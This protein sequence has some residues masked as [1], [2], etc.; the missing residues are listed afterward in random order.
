MKSFCN[1]FLVL[2]T[3]GIMFSGCTLD[4][5]SQQSFTPY[6]KEISEF[7]QKVHGKPSESI[8]LQILEDQ[9]ISDEE[10]Q[11]LAQ[12]QIKCM[13]DAGIVGYTIDLNT[14]VTEFPPSN[15][16]TQDQRDFEVQDSCYE[17]TYFQWIQFLY[18]TMR[19]NP[20]NL[21]FE[22]VL[23]SCLVKLKV[24]DP[25]YNAAE[26]RERTEKWAENPNKT[27]E[28]DPAFAVP[29]IVD[30]ETGREAFYRCNTDP[31]SVLK[32]TD[33]E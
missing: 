3:I 20:Q 15:S 21:P 4:I 32:S 23:A 11:H 22:D 17:Q 31:Q 5:E 26:H 29:Y 33:R 16:E 19:A 7:R 14:G 1:I 8:V 13:E 25:S 12:T 9:H 24:V 6:S 18:L 10:I 30:P 28:E 27:A 2:P